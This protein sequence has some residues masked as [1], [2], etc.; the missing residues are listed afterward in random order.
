MIWQYSHYHVY[1][2][3]VRIGLIIVETFSVKQKLK[4]NIWVEL[5]F[6]MHAFTP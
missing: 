3:Y 5:F 6:C 1:V 4:T 2:V